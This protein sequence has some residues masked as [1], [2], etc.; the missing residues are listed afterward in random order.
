MKKQLAIVSQLESDEIKVIY[1][2]LTSLKEL[3]YLISSVSKE[4]FD[5]YHQDLKKTNQEY[6]EWWVKI[7]AKYNLPV[8]E[9]KNWEFDF[10]TNTIFLL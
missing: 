7:S 8:F 6:Q 10:R 5:S 2:H 3:E 1:A 4:V 9:E